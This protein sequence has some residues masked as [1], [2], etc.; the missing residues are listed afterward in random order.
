MPFRYSGNG[1]RVAGS[2]ETFGDQIMEARGH[3]NS[4]TVDGTLGDLE[5]SN[6]TSDHNRDDDGIV[7]ALDFFEHEPG[8]VDAIGEALRASKDPRLKYFI[9]DERMF[10]SYSNSKGPAWEWREYTGVNGHINHGHLSVV[11]TTIADQTHEWDLGENMPLTNDDIDAIWYRLVT[12][13]VTGN[14][15]G[16]QALLAGARG[17]AYRAR[18]DAAV[19]RQLIE[20]VAAESPEVSLSAEDIAALGAQIAEKVKAEVAAEIADEFSERLAD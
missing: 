9:H 10:A 4:Y 15:R 14:Q 7:R 18:V 16:A 8:F 19:S 3:T 6:R 20:Q 13:P 12:D 5:H 2:I 11:A 17:D 1:W